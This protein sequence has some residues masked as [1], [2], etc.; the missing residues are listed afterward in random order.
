MVREFRGLLAFCSTLAVALLILLASYGQ[1][2][3]KPS[4]QLSSEVQDTLRSLGAGALE[5]EDVPVGA[6]ILYGD[7]VIGAGSNVVAKNLDAGGHAEIQAISD[8]FRRVGI[9]RFKSLDRDSLILVTTFE[10]CLMCRGAILEYHIRNVTF[11]KGKPVGL[12][13]RED[14]RTFRYLWERDQGG[15]SDLQDSLFVRH[16]L[17]Q[18]R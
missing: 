8:A 7:S 16:P 5:S 11:L 13:L 12:W 2:H 14:L 3:L 6:V 17:Y 9:E 10:P 15:S 1:W 4:R 18:K